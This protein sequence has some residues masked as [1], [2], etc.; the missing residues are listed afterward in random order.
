MS[1]MKDKRHRKGY[2]NEFLV[3][4]FYLRQGFK[5]VAHRFKT[6]FAEVDLICEDKNQDLVIVEVKTVSDSFWNS[7]RISSRQKYRLKN[8]TLHL[9]EQTSK[10]VEVHLAFVD[11]DGKID[12]LKDFLS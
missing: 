1:T 3:G 9:M 7:S 11:K 5:I 4:Q 12:I 10:N 6:P 8:A 2:R